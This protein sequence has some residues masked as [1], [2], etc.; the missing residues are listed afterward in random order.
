MMPPTI[1]DYYRAAIHGA[2]KEIESTSDDRVIGMDAEEW[3]E[4]LTGKWGMF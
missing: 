1:G 2:K 3:I 4:Y